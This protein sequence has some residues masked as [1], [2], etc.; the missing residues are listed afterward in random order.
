MTFTIKGDTIMNRTAMKILATL[1]LLASSQVFAASSTTGKA[2]YDA[3]K[4]EALSRYNADK[5]LCTEETT[6]SARMQC[7]R[8][9]QSEY[10][11]ALATAKAKQDEMKKAAAALPAAAAQATTAVCKECG[12]VTAVNVGEKEGKGG[13]LGVI[14]GGVAGAVLGHQVGQGTGQDVA[15]IAGAAGGAYAGHKIEQRMGKTKFWTVSVHFDSGE[16]RSFTFDNDPG[17]SV[18]DLVKTSDN[19]IVK[20]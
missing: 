15:T 4:K 7:K 11:K 9:A 14:A 16:K 17:L 3:D 1:M 6:S 2:Q 18:G 5:K 20:R 10:K 12:K 19:S 13:P 8:D